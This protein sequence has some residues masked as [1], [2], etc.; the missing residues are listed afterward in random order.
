METVLLTVILFGALALA[1]SFVT[2]LRRKTW[3]S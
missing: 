2:D 3:K 1:G